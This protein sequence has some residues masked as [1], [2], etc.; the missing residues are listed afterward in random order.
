[1]PVA[2]ACNLSYLGGRDWEDRNSKPAWANSSQHPSSK[3]TL[4]EKGLVEWLKVEALSSNPS[5][6]KKKKKKNGDHSYMEAP[7]LL[8][9]LFLS[10]NQGTLDSFWGKP[11]K[12]LP[13]CQAQRCTPILGRLRWEDHLSP[14]VQ[15]HPGQ[16]RETPSLR[17][18]KKNDLGTSGEGTSGSPWECVPNL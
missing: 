17:R 1:M 5:A 12:H 7:G 9:G 13:L 2:H 18:T 6:T 10:G 8:P 14:G 4:H 11:S 16:Q 15:D 3:K